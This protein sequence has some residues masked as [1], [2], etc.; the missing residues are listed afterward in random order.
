M[1]VTLGHR[2]YPVIKY[3]IVLLIVVGV[4]LFLYKD[5]GGQSQTEDQ[6]KLFNILG[7]GE[8][9]LVRAHSLPLSSS[10]LS[11][12]LSL[13]LPHYPPLPLPFFPTLS[14]FLLPHYPL[15]SPL[16]FITVLFLTTT[17]CNCI[18]VK[19]CCLYYLIVP[20]DSLLDVRR[21]DWSV[22]RQANNQT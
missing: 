6:T 15:L 20:T 4:A 10:P 7:I 14:L 18:F 21:P 19:T 12:T 9:L 11:P 13:F 8:F 3:L 5:K 1:G 17:H 16:S 2:R 22:S